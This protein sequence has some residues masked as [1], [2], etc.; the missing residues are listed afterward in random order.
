MF[1]MRQI[2]VRS[3]WRD[4]N[5][6]PLSPLTIQFPDYCKIRTEVHLIRN[7]HFCEE[8]SFLQSLNCEFLSII[9]TIAFV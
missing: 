9:T 6:K 5:A 8:I 7:K 4:N 2:F 1:L 3:Y